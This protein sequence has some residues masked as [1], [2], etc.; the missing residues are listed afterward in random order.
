MHLSSK[1]EQN[2]DDMTANS[3][4]TML[5]KD[6]SFLPE[7]TTPLGVSG[8]DTREPEA[9]TGSTNTAAMKGALKSMGAWRR[10]MKQVG[11]RLRKACETKIFLTQSLIGSR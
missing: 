7:N 2:H 5:V 1:N 11:E 4:L 9:V 3:V 6:A 10:I 8:K